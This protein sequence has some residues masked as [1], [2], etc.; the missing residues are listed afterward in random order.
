[1][2][3]GVLHVLHGIH[4]W[5]RKSMS[6][7]II[8]AYARFFAQLIS[9]FRREDSVA[10]RGKHSKVPTRETFTGQGVAVRESAGQ[11][12]KE[13]ETLHVYKYRSTQH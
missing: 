5:N 3:R 12:N 10:T 9:R 1:M 7:A 2:D 11:Q 6:R 8:F 4:R 13:K